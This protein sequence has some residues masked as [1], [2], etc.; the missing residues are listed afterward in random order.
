M[1]YKIL[2]RQMYELI[3]KMENICPEMFMDFGAWCGYAD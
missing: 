2:V 3:K 1:F